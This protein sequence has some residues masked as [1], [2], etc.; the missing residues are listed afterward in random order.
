MVG[1]ARRALL[2]WVVGNLLA[3]STVLVSLVM[4][5]QTTLALCRIWVAV[6]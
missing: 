4:R 3:P 5:C 6:V 2:R 1:L